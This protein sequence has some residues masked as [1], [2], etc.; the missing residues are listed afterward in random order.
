MR[1]ESLTVY[2][3]EL[4]LRK[5]FRHAS[6]TRHTSENLFV[7]CRL[8][9]GTTGW[10]EGVPRDYVT[11]ETPQGCIERLAATNVSQQLGGDFASW[12]DVVRMIDQFAPPEDASDARGSGDNSLR[13]AVEL[14]LLDAAG[15]HFGQPVADLAQH[16]P[17]VEAIVAPSRRVRYSTTI[18]AEH[19]AKLW[20]S[21][22]KMRAWGF[23]QCKVKVGVDTAGDSD[24]L[25]IVRRWIGPRVDLR[26]D[27]NEAWQP[28]EV[29]SRLAEFAGVRVSCIEQPVAHEQLAE[30]ATFKSGINVP[31][32]LDESLTSL[33]DAERAVELGVCDLLNLRISKCGGYINCLRLAAFAHRH[34]LGYQLGCHPGESGILS[35]AGRHWATSVRDIRYLEGSYDHHVLRVLPTTPDMTFGYGGVAPRLT[36]PGLGVTVDRAVFDSLVT[37]QQRF[38]L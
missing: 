4:P 20:K 34:G 10:G 7:E 9:N 22:L 6:H 1:I 36:A 30:F 13:A 31:V 18:D 12:A 5:P 33:A 16:V 35:A 25:R 21:A 27:A 24:R 19:A 38:D 26:L 3:A 15:K 8:E 17:G 28:R 2:T 23:R 29:E 14:S 37:A 11:G 32:M